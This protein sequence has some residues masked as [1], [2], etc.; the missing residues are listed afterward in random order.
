MQYTI[1]VW[2]LI[3][4]THLVLTLEN[5]LSM[6][7]AHDQCSYAWLQVLSQVSEWKKAFFWTWLPHTHSVYALT[8]P[9]SSKL[10]QA[11]WKTCVTGLTG[12]ISIR[13][14]IFSR[15]VS[16]EVIIATWLCICSHITLAHQLIQHI[17][18]TIGDTKGQ[19]IQSC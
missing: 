18:S 16:V 11:E 10:A 1:S 14:L 8:S 13:V 7:S 2:A 17:Y 5:M 12:Y 6:L 15:R 4:H 3:T 9:I 19:V